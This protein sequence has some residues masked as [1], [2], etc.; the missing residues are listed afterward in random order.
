MNGLR[1]SSILADP[2]QSDT[3]FSIAQADISRILDIYR[4]EYRYVTDAGISGFR[5]SCKLRQVHYPYTVNEVFKYVTAPTATFL[6]CQLA[7]VLVGGLILVGN[8][9]ASSIL[10]WQEFIQFRDAAILRFTRCDTLFRGEV[11]NAQNIPASISICRHRRAPFGRY[12]SMSFS[13]GG[14]I[15]GKIHGAIVRANQ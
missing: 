1:Q 15:T 3:I 13:I 8:E 14:G 5:L 9:V 2:L 6:A 12:C 10:S 11:A 7:Y 4:P